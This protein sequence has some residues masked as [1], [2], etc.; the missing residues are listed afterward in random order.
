M[1]KKPTSME[2]NPNDLKTVLMNKY[3]N[4][5]LD[6]ITER[7]LD[8]LRYYLTRQYDKEHGWNDECRK[9]FEQKLRMFM[10]EEIM[11]REIAG[12]ESLLPLLT[13]EDIRKKRAHRASGK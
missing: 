10:H 8:E 11:R 12:I 6:K 7:D 4:L 2:S 5:L 9:R 1:P 13:Y 3:Q